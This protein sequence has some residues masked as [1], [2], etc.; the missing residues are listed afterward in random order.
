[1]VSL[2]GKLGFAGLLFLAVSMLL[3]SPS[4]GGT[5]TENFD[6]NQYDKT[7]WHKYVIGPGVSG[8]LF[9]NRLEITLPQSSGG[10]QYQGGMGS[11]FLVAG[12]FEMQVDFDL[13]TWPANNASQI[14]L[15][16]N[17]AY[18]FSIIPPQP[19]AK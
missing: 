16:L 4:Q 13:L 17:Q 9:N 3:V 12:D 18:D 2:R 8:G 6:N 1:M 7:L 14:G 5:I 11:E 15:T 19:R 10:T